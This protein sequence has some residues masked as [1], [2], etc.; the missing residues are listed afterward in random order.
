MIQTL[1]G[2]T[3]TKP[4]LLQ[5]F[6]KA[7]QSTKSNLVAR[8]DEVVRGKKEIDAA[9]LED[10]EQ[11]LIGGDVGLATTQEVLEAV[12]NSVDR[13]QMD[14]AGE[15]K[16]AVK[17]E[18]M[19]ILNRTQSGAAKQVDPPVVLL[20]VGVNGTGKTT[21]IGKLAYHLGSHGKKVL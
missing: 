5:R 21:T 9:L 7:V 20:V 11:V 2:P 1:F 14:N 19:G 12:R 8:M 16:A 13:G 15:L 6:Q 3:E 17:N 4:G 10:L 18:L